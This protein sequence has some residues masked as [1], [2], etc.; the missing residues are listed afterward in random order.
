[1]KRTSIGGGLYKDDRK[2]VYWVR[3]WVDGRRTWRHLR[4]VTERLAL[5]EARAL[6]TDH[7]RSRIGTAKSPFAPQSDTFADM[8]DLYLAAKCPDKR[9][10]TRAL[11]F[12]AVEADRITYLKRFFGRKTLEEIRLP[13]LPKYKDWRVANREKKHFTGLRA[14][15]LELV[16]LSNVLSYA[17]SIGRLE[18]NR[19]RS[20]RPKFQTADKVSHSRERSIESGDDL[21]KLAQYLFQS[22][23]SE[24]MGWLLLFSAMTGCRNVELLSLR[25]DATCPEEPGFIQNG[26]LFLRRAKRGLNPWIKLDGEFGEM[27][28]SFLKWHQNRFPNSPWFFPGRTPSEM[29]Q[30]DS[31]RHALY[32]ASARVAIGR[33][34]PHGLRSF[35]VTKRRSDGIADVQIAAEIGDRTV[36]LISQTYGD[37]PPNWFGQKKLSFLPTEGEPAWRSQ[38][39]TNP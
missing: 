12:C 20:G 9:L 1:V 26:Y 38:F 2:G 7:A 10:Q 21:H 27:V 19:L 6:L 28:E 13:L 16:T 39:Q 37:V 14:V 4:A 17:V 8:A 18:I 22:R 11:G 30:K 5:E 25:F 32:R 15:D 24:V 29:I 34:S 35:Y 31:F 36:S 3:P 33:C 23:G